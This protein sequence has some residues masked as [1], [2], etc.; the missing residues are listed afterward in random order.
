MHNEGNL[1]ARPAHTSLRRAWQCHNRPLKLQERA[2]PLT[3]RVERCFT[4]FV[5]W[6]CG[7]RLYNILPA[8]ETAMATMGSVTNNVQLWPWR[9]LLLLHLHVTFA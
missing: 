4:S 1:L 7:H 8:Y 9:F 6:C 3:R 5:A 2:Q